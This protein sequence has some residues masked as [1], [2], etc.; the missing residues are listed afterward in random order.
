MKNINLKLVIANIESIRDTNWDHLTHFNKMV[1]ED[2][3]SLIEDEVITENN[4]TKVKDI[5][6]LGYYISQCRFKDK[7]LGFNDFLELVSGAS[8]GICGTEEIYQR[9]L[10]ADQF[11][12]YQND[13][14]D[15]SKMRGYKKGLCDMYLQAEAYYKAFTL[16]SH[17]IL[18][19]I[20]PLTED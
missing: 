16:I 1:I 10:D 12:A 11:K 17:I 3:L 6:E 4:V 14:L 15:M 7:L 8:L 13:T 9:Y 5:Y 19:V 2:A 20:Y 18:D